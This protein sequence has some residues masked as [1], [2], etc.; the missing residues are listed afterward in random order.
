M[1]KLYD[2]GNLE[3]KELRAFNGHTDFV[4]YVDLSSDETFIVSASK[5]KTLKIWNLK[6]G[7]SITLTGHLKLVYCCT[8]SPDNKTVA[9]SSSDC[10]IK[11]W[12]TQTGKELFTL[13]G[14]E[15][16]VYSVFYSPNGRYLLSGGGILK[17]V[18]WDI[19]EKKQLRVLLQTKRVSSVNISPNN[20]YIAV[21]AWDKLVKLYEFETTKILNVIEDAECCAI[22]NDYIAIFTYSQHNIRI[23]KLHD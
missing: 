2:F 8:I 7:E 23:Y 5:D 1:I 21:A 6:T 10:D 18:V 14:H 13:M 12:D 17:V 15:W 20:K 22:N 19:V 16:D 4:N 9:S 3:G 11:I